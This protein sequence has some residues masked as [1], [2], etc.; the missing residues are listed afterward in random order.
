MDHSQRRSEWLNGSMALRIAKIASIAKMCESGM[1][2]TRL[3]EQ[4]KSLL[5]AGDSDAA[6]V[7]ETGATLKRDEEI[8]H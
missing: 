5:R 1:R 2:A 3:R 8:R 7:D 4:V 6:G